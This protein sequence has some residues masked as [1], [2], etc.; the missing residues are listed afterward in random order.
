MKIINCTI[1]NNLAKTAGGILIGSQ[2]QMLLDGSPGNCNIYNSILYG[3]KSLGSSEYGYDND[4][5]CSYVGVW[6][7][8]NHGK[9]T[10]DYCLIGTGLSSQGNPSN[11][12]SLVKKFVIDYFEP[13]FVGSGENPYMLSKNSRCIDRGFN[14]YVDEQFDI[15]GKKYLRKLNGKDSTLEN[16]VD[17]GAY[18]FNYPEDAVSVNETDINSFFS[19]YPN[20]AGNYISLSESDTKLY[21]S[22]EIY[23]ISGRLL[24]KSIFDSNRID[25]SALESGFYY[26]RL[27]SP[28]GVSSAGFLK[29]K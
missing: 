11:P 28:S 6:E 23:D 18:E 12:N 17:I 14:D 29:M 25:I 4:L 19:V 24:Q 3:N 22:Y 1:T 13:K 8:K 9:T 2:T 27:L 15:R 5:L 7:S 26:L 21:E 16:I 20:P 10:L